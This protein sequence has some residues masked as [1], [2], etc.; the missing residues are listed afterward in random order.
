MKGRKPRPHSKSS[1]NKTAKA[2][3]RN[4][5][6][7]KIRLNRFISNS[8]LCSRRAADELIAAGKV[9]VNGKLVQEMGFKVSLSDKVQVD[10]KI[11]SPEKK[12]YLLMNKPGGVIC[13]R[14]D[15]RGRRTVMDMLPAEY[16]HLYPVGRLDRNTTGVLLITNDGELTQKLLHPSKKVKKVYKVKLDRDLSKEEMEKLVEGVELDDGTSFFDQL[17]E[18]KEDKEPRYGVEIHSGKNRIIRRMFESVGARVVKLDR[19]LFHT[20]ERRGMQR[21]EFRPLRDKE[22][23]TLGVKF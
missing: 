21:G 17:A 13:T 22:L 7:E 2:K 8:G 12:I 19:V 5:E 6:E 11:V 20:L 1:Q 9:K 4:A 14:K 10:N 23:R 18:L 3:D 16:Q 15:E